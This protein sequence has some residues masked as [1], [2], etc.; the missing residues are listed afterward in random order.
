[1]EN[2]SSF[3]TPAVGLL[4]GILLLILESCV[5]GLHQK[6]DLPSITPNPSATLEQ[7]MISTLTV[8]PLP[9]QT[10]TKLPSPPAEPTW[11]AFPTVPSDL[12]D[13]FIE[14]MNNMCELPCWGEITPEKTSEMEAKHIL[15]S[16]GTI[17]ESTSIYFHYRQKAAVIDLTFMDGIVHTINLPPQLTESYRLSELLSRYGVP[18]DVRME[19]I[20]ETADGTP[21]Y[22]LAI[23]YP[24]E[25]VLAVFSGEGKIINSKVNVCFGNI[26][27]DLYLVGSN[28]Y[29]LD[30]MDSILDPTL[31]NALKPISS[32]AKLSGKQ[33]YD[34]FSVPTERCLATTI[35]AP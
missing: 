21:W 24:Q 23:F 22:D 26:S 6:N 19:V 18:A 10:H 12:I 27:P 32:L 20:P 9:I 13:S 16:F 28:H 8:T 14:S 11:T 3:S 2:R 35:Q 1:M 31:K 5:S 17:I 4:F 33:F 25:G 34:T 7:A 15:S 30:Q 29:S